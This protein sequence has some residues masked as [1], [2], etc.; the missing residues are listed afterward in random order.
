MQ[1]DRIKTYL[2]E[3][4]EEKTREQ[5]MQALPEGCDQAETEMVIGEFWDAIKEG[6]LSEEDGRQLGTKFQTAFQD[7]EL[8]E[9]EVDELLEFMRDAAGLEEEQ[10]DQPDYWGG[11][12]DADEPTE[13]APT[14]L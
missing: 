9:N 2:L 7:G 12:P 11:E 1:C 8:T 5:I 14:E 4:A 3:V 10:G 6:R 13:E